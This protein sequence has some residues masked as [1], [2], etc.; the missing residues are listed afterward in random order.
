MAIKAMTTNNEEV[1]PKL[2]KK[3]IR[4]NKKTI[5]ELYERLQDVEDAYKEGRDFFKKELLLDIESQEKKGNSPHQIID[6]V[7]YLLK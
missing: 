5:S 3:V 4:K 2:M 6:I 7:K 1:S